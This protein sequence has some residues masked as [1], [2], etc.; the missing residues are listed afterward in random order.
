MICTARRRGA[1]Q[2]MPAVMR[3][4]SAMVSRNRLAHRN[5]CYQH[6]ARCRRCKLC[7]RRQRV[8][9][10]NR[11]DVCLQWHQC[12]G[13]ERHGH[14]VR[15][16]RRTLGLAPLRRL[17]REPHRERRA[18]RRGRHQRRC[19]RRINILQPPGLPWSLPER[20]RWGRGSRSRCGFPH[21]GSGWWRY[22]RR[23][24]SDSSTSAGSPWSTG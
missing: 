7:A 12:C 22:G 15:W 13:P 16:R 9:R 24:R 6:A 21:C 3:P 18:L 4:I 17:S 14:R 11:D 19:G 23:S 1:Q 5:L 2:S 20:C 8:H 10:G